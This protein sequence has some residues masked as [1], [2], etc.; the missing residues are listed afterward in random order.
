RFQLPDPS[1]V[2][3]QIKDVFG[4]LVQ[5]YEETEMHFGSS[6]FELNTSNLA[7]G[8]YLVEVTSVDETFGRKVL[9]LQVN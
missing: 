4:R 3:I 8:H 1:R 5:Q 9:K 6:E 7:A 2:I